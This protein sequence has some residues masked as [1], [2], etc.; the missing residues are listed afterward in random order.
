[1]AGIHTEFENEEVAEDSVETS[2]MDKPHKWSHAMEVMEAIRMNTALPGTIQDRIRIPASEMVLE[3]FHCALKENIL[4]QG[5]LYIFPHYIGFTC[6]LPGH[7]RS[8]VIALSDVDA[9]DKAKLG[10]IPN[11]IQIS[12]LD[13]TYFFTSFF[14]RGKAY[15]TIYHLW[16]IAKGLSVC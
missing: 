1:M 5:I 9:L 13:T 10:I 15:E 14:S 12:A 4:L 7:S 3:K 16:A 2:K 11:S 6:D 8:I